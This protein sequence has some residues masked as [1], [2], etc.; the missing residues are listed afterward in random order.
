MQVHPDDA[1]AQKYGQ[2]RGKTECWYALAAEPDAEVAVG[3]KPG[4]TLE[5]VRNEIRNGTLEVEPPA[6][7]DRRR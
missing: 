3:L 1:L 4:V 7:A 2:P 5:Q 6:V